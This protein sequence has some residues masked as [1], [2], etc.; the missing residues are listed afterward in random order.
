MNPWTR[1]PVDKWTSG[2]GTNNLYLYLYLYLAACRNPRSFRPWVG[3][4]REVCAE[5][6]A[7][8][9]RADAFL[10]L[11]ALGVSFGGVRGGMRADAFP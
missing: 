6:S 5:G 1:G 11:A 9:M 8:G 2:P 3:Y 7:E 10:A 4:A